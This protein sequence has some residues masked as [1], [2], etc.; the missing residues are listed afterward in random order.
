MGVIFGFPFRRP[1]TFALEC[2]ETHLRLARGEEHGTTLKLTHHAEEEL[3]R[4]LFEKRDE[5]GVL[6]VLEKLLK[7]VEGYS[8]RDTVLLL[9]SSWVYTCFLQCTS[10][11][12]TTGGAQAA[13][14][15]V[16][17]EDLALL[18]I[19]TKVLSEQNGVIS[20]GA[21]AVRSSLFT[22]LERA[23]GRANLHLVCVTTLPCILAVCH[24]NKGASKEDTFIVS[25]PGP[26]LSS[27]VT[28][29]HHGWPI[30]E[31]VLYGKIGER[32]V[33]MD[34]HALFEEYRGRHFLKGG[35]LS[36]YGSA[37]LIRECENLVGKIQASEPWSVT[38]IFPTVVGT[39]LPWLGLAAAS[40]YNLDRLSMNFAQK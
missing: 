18:S 26:S 9:P 17:P 21:A 13:M 38:A 37:E 5:A 15:K 34:L 16:F 35:T 27:T 10:T 39:D 29:F 6:A 2:T 14:T 32:E 4:E 23:C 30:D 20:L 8:V 1:Q 11:E 33:I 31:S 28:L 22:T 19:K 25:A 36:V 7:G 24:E 40:T 3:P 12:M